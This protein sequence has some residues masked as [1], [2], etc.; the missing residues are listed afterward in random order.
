MNPNL[1]ARWD[2]SNWFVCGGQVSLKDDNFLEIGERI[3]M[4]DEK[5]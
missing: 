2:G 1:V 4:P 5:K 3:K